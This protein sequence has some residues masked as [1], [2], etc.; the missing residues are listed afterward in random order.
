MIEKDTTRPSLPL[1]YPM[2]G[3]KLVTM[4]TALSGLGRTEGCNLDI[5]SQ[6]D[7]DFIKWTLTAPNKDNA[8]SPGS[9]KCMALTWQLF[10][11]KT[12]DEK[13]IG[14]THLVANPDIME[15]TTRT[16]QNND[17]VWETRMTILWRSEKDSLDVSP[18]PENRCRST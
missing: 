9:S 15:H 4:T 17:T 5:N 1:S 8:E 10:L 11:T 12:Q 18:Q 6:L 13:R 14:T 3:L 7:N 2:L 16:K